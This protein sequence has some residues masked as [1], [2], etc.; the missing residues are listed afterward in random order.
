MGQADIAGVALAG[1]KN[2]SVW[3]EIHRAFLAHSVIVFREQKL[4]PADIMAVGGRFGPPCYYPF[5]TGMEG[6][7]YIFEIVKEPEDSR[8]FGGAW[9]SDSSYQ[10]QPRLATLLYAVETPSAGGDTL[11]T[12]TYAAYDA[13]SDGMKKMLEPLKGEFSGE[14]KYAGGR[15]SLHKMNTGRSEERRVGKECRS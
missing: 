14:L 3:D 8:N 7:P 9:H 13:L 15:T 2:D 10:K 6:F 4:E 5:V 1:L 11:F 12:S